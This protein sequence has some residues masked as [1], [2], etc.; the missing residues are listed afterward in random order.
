MGSFFATLFDRGE[1]VERRQTGRT[2]HCG[3][4]A[5]DKE[6]RLLVVEIVE[7]LPQQLFIELGRVDTPQAFLCFYNLTHVV[8]QYC[9]SVYPQKA[10]VQVLQDLLAHV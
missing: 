8:P 5:G 9:L 6:G 4:T 7:V 2:A 1:G 3:H 10:C